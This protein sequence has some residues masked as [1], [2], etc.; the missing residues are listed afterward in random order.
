MT[1]VFKDFCVTRYSNF[2]SIPSYHRFRAWAKTKRDREETAKCPM[3]VEPIVGNPA[4]QPASQQAPVDTPGGT[5][6]SA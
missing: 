3:C 4:S 2:S 6:E 1:S 5:Q